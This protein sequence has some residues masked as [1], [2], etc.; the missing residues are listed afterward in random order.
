MYKSEERCIEDV[1]VELVLIEW[2]A[3]WLCL[4]MNARSWNT[5]KGTRYILYNLNYKL[6]ANHKPFVLHGMTFTLHQETSWELEWNLRPCT[7][8]SYHHLHVRP[9]IVRLPSP[10][11]TSDH[12]SPYTGSE[13]FAG[14][15]KCKQERSGSDWKGKSLKRERIV[16]GWHWDSAERDDDALAVRFGGCRRNGWSV[17][18]R[19]YWSNNNFL[20]WISNS[21]YIVE[22]VEY[23]QYSNNCRESIPIMVL[24]L[25]TTRRLSSLWLWLWPGSARLPGYKYISA[26]GSNPVS[27]KSSGACV[28]S[29]K[30]G[31]RNTTSSSPK[32]FINLL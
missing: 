18:I 11:P 23:F 22:Y 26:S 9:T 28:W 21:L 8:T 20:F 7:S 31:W 15:E 2:S 14:L 3:Y 5:E 24:K 17:I 30:C 19:S 10:Q 12:Q 6:T 4:L 16:V 27:L 25:P 13:N 29:N 32:L 1:W